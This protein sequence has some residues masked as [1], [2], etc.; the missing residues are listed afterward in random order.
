MLKRPNY[1]MILIIFL[2]NTSEFAYFFFMPWEIHEG[3]QPLL[4][5]PLLTWWLSHWA[6][7]HKLC[8]WALG[9]QFPL[10]QLCNLNVRYSVM[11]LSTFNGVPLLYALAFHNL[12][13]NSRCVYCTQYA[14]LCHINSWSDMQLQW[15]GGEGRQPIFHC[16]DIVRQFYRADTASLVWPPSRVG[17]TCFENVWATAGFCDMK[18][19]PRN[20]SRHAMST[21]SHSKANCFKRFWKRKDKL[22]LWTNSGD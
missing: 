21:K 1:C 12:A 10:Y 9:M 6:V 3:R 15:W 14:A 2:V 5:P 22:W 13:L 16:H 19:L 4:V 11:F 18:Y 7:C 17:E 20:L 8:W